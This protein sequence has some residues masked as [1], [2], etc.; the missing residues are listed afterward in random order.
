MENSIKIQFT[1]AVNVIKNLPKDGYILL[2]FK[3]KLII[4]M[5]NEL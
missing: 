1:S 3:N 4:Y 2:S 5:Y